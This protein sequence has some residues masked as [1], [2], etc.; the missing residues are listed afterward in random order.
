MGRSVC[1]LAQMPFI[2]MLTLLLL[3]A[4]ANAG[5]VFNVSCVCEGVCG[6]LM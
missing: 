5:I 4:I 1:E 2:Y 3:A 6:E